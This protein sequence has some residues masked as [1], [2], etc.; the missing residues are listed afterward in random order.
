MLHSLALLCKMLFQAASP[1]DY[2]VFLVKTQT[3]R[4][5]LH[6]PGDAVSHETMGF[7]RLLKYELTKFNLSP[8]KSR[9]TVAFI[10]KSV[11]INSSHYLH[12]LSYLTQISPFLPSLLQIRDLDRFS[13]KHPQPDQTLELSYRI[14]DQLH[15]SV[16]VTHFGTHSVQ[17]GDENR[18]VCWSLRDSSL[19]PTSLDT[20]DIT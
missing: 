5:V 3:A 10:F 14:G 17:C 19:K 20:L 15:K 6:L 12:K 13:L 11:L 18:F 4:R 8:V 9:S 1:Q 2:P 7:Q 16:L